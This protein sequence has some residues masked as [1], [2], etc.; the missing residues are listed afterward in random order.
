M[1]RAPERFRGG[2]APSALRLGHVVD[3]VGRPPEA[4]PCGIVSIL[5]FVHRKNTSP[6]PV[7]DR[8]GAGARQEFLG[9]DG[10]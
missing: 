3:E 9:A 5:Q 1:V 2:I 10:S 4:L 6:A 7:E 8:N